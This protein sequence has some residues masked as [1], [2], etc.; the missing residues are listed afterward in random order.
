MSHGEQGSSLPATEECNEW[1][2]FADERTIGS[3][4]IYSGV[5]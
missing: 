4:M 5:T 2:N 3:Y 1:R